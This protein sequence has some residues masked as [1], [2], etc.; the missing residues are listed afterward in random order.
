MV[1]FV[2]NNCGDSFKKNAVEKHKM[3]AYCRNSSVSCVD[4]KKDFW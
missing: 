2:C 4:C 1:V 3:K